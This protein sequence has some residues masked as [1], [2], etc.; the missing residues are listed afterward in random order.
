MMLD[1][2]CR[3]LESR[4]RRGNIQNDTYTA[5]AGNRVVKV[6]AEQNTSYFFVNWT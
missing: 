2:Y 5:A 6:N 4:Y 3:F 1:V